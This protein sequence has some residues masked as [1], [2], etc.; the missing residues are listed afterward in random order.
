VIAIYPPLPTA[1]RSTSLSLDDITKHTTER[2]KTR[3]EA[4][5]NL[6]QSYAF[7][8]RPSTMTK[9]SQDRRKVELQIG[10]NKT[11]FHALSHWPLV[12]PGATPAISSL[13]VCIEASGETG[14]LQ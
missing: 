11:D 10:S 9:L 4:G 8:L 12:H 2:L 7:W 5:L 3:T 14:F 13:S 6:R 1:K